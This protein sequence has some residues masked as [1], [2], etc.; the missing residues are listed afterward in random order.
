MRFF[1]WLYASRRNFLT[2]TATAYAVPMYALGI[3]LADPPGVLMYVALLLST[4]AAGGL[5]ALIA[6]VTFG[7]SVVER[8]DRNAADHRPSRS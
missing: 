3:F 1:R 6:W 4:A 8:L 7:K 2:A 5:F